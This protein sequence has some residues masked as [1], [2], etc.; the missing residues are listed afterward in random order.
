MKQNDSL[1]GIITVLMRWKKS[2]ILLT[3]LAAI[4]SIIVAMTLPVYFKASTTFYAAHQDQFKAS[5]IFGASDRET[6]IYGGQEDVDR[7]TTVANSGEIKDHLV[8]K[9]NL[10]DHYGMGDDRGPAAR[11]NIHSKM[12]KLYEVR[13]TKHDAL[14]IIV[15]DEDPQVAADMANEAR[16]HVDKV[17]RDLIR[18]SQAKIMESFEEKIAK[19]EALIQLLQDS[20]QKEK[21]RYGIYDVKTQSETLGMLAAESES[22]LMREKAKL[23]SLENSPG[24]NQ[25][26][27]LYLRARVDGLENQLRSLTSSS[28]KGGFNLTRFNEGK[29]IV[30]NLQGQYQTNITQLSWDIERYRLIKDGQGSD[31]SAIHLI[32]KAEIPAIKSRP[33]RTI[34]VAGATIA[35]FLFSV[36]LALLLDA[37]KNVNWKEVLHG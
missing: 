8:E 25:D 31:I 27:I 14:M 23:R 3:A 1:L 20:L 34:L 7:I 28:S 21:K 22:N 6:Y 9:F 12:A 16:I 11:F 2:I 19:R 24:V 32:E 37:Y 15:E 35:A 5:K 30:E 36:L 33:R 29:P 13:K 18:N 17:N 10:Y 4:G 26:T